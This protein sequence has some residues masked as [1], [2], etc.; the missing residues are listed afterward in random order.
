VSG[1]KT[2]EPV[3]MQCV[4]LGQVGPGN[5]VFGG[6]QMPPLQGALWGV[7]PIEKHCTTTILRPFFRD[8]PVEP[9]PE[10]NF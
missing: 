9:V 5:H 4:M 7:W 8:H 1:A 6:M 10:E 2:A 3:E